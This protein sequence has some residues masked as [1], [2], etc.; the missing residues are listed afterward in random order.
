[1][2]KTKLF[3]TDL[4][5]LYVAVLFNTFFLP[6]NLLVCSSVLASEFS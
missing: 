4:L 1:M 6:K 2:K 5:M 3:D